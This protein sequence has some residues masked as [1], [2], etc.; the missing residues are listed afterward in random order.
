MNQNMY[1]ETKPSKTRPIEIEQELKK[2]VFGQDEYLKKLSVIAARHLTN[3]DLVSKGL[4][5][6]NNNSLIIG[7]SGSGKT[8]A[9]KKLAKIIDVPFIEIDGSTLQGNSYVGCQHVSTM[10]YNYCEKLGVR[11]VSRAILFI[12]E[13]D[14]TLDIY[15]KNTTGAH[16][17]QRDLLKLFE[18]NKNFTVNKSVREE[19]Q[20]FNLDTRCMTIICAGSYDEAY[21][22]YAGHNRV[23]RDNKIGFLNDDSINE[24]V[25]TDLDATDLIELGNLPELIGRFSSIVNINSLSSDDIFNIFKNGNDSSIRGYRSYLK[26]FGVDLKIEDSYYRFIA[27]NVLK[28]GTGFRGAEKFV[29]KTFDEI[30]Y[31][32]QNEDNV[33]GVSINYKDSYLIITYLYNNGRKSVSKLDVNEYFKSIN[34]NILVTKKRSYN[35]LLA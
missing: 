13:F 20:G 12:D 28:D 5:P 11:A 25:K 2:S 14:K 19:N 32:V 18:N 24:P 7:P 22:A 33:V 9:I 4:N 30:I 1:Q 34:S 10:L 27:D 29:N 6:V 26:S 31:N 23:I 3:I 21:T 8:F 35:S 17:V 15:I 16:V